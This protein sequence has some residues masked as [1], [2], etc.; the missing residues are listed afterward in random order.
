MKKYFLL[1]ISTLLLWRC[2]NNTDLSN[3][4]FFEEYY[5][6]YLETEKE[7]KAYATFLEGDSIQNAKPKIFFAGVAFQ[8]SGME[9]RNLPKGVVKYSITNNNVSYNSPFRFRYRNEEGQAVEER[10]NMKPLG[11]F[12]VK[13]QISLSKGMTLVINNGSLSEDEQLIFL[14]SD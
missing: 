10:L 5:V 9:V 2:E 4:I 12:F 3:D 6:R 13:D 11:D 14:F 1:A 7:L 8:N